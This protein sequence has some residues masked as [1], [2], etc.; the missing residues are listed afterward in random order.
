MHEL[1]IGRATFG[2]LSLLV[3]A[4]LGACRALTEPADARYCEKLNALARDTAQMQLGATRQFEATGFAASGTTGTSCLGV[5]RGAFEY[6]TD[7]PAVATVETA[8][9]VVTARAT[10]NTALRARYVLEGVTYR[11]VLT[12]SIVP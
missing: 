9:G 11:G 5:I 4:S 6:S 2:A 7:D 8:T 12:L 10:G 3:L 1:R